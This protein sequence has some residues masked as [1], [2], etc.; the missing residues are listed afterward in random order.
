MDAVVGLA[1][2]VVGALMATTSQ[3]RGWL[4]DQRLEIYAEF[5]TR[6]DAASEAAANYVIRA[7]GVASMDRDSYA[8]A[9]IQAEVADAWRRLVAAREALMTQYFRVRLVGTAVAGRVSNELL[10]AVTKVPSLPFDRGY[11]TWD[12]AAN[13]LEA[14]RGELGALDGQRIALFL[15]VAKADVAVGPK[16]YVLRQWLTARILRGRTT[17][18]IVT[19]WNT[20]RQRK[21]PTDA[22]STQAPL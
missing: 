11:E 3:R 4:R 14:I 17:S 16:A 22:S 15:E 10:R 21:R 13:E 20:R 8:Q 12:R 1:G 6:Y 5:A 2:V 18:A 9:Y 19:I 7:N